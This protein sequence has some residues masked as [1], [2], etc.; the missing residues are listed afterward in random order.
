[1]AMVAVVSG[2]VLA[3]CGKDDKNNGT[4][5]SYVDLALHSGTKWKN[6]N[7]E[8]AADAEYNFYTF[9]EAV[10]AFGNN[11]PT[12]E[13]LEELKINCQWEW[14]GNGYRVTGGNGNS[15]FLPAASYRLCSGNGGTVEEVGSSGSYW[16]STQY[17][18]S[19]SAGYLI[20]SRYSVIVGDFA[21]C[22]GRSI[23][24]VQD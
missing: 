6:A 13:Q 3:S 15:I 21:Q 18:E 19:S 4:K 1:M 14:K 24:L 12:Q 2:M 16:S 22:Y 23:R 10:A 8:N 7:E 20:F 9:E 17:S 11:L 5:D